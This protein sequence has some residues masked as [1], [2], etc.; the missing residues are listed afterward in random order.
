M[1]GGQSVLPYRTTGPE[2]RIP[3]KGPLLAD[4]RPPPGPQRGVGRTERPPL[5]PGGAGRLHQ[6][7][8][9]LWVDA[10]ARG[11]LDTFGLV[12][13]LQR[14][15][16]RRVAAGELL[17]QRLPAPPERLDLR[18]CRIE[19]GLARRLGLRD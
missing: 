2:G 12:H 6:V 3:G 16:D 11:F 15:K 18:A 9:E 13:L 10:A 1:W 19:A 17:D 7:R 4:V 14:P 5:R 8:H